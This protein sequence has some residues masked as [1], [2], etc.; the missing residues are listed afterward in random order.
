MWFP[1]D[2]KEAPVAKAAYLAEI[3]FMRIQF[4]LLLGMQNEK[5][6]LISKSLGNAYPPKL[7]VLAKLDPMIE[8]LCRS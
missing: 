3:F 8:L 6:Q 2:L 7:I 1:L 4:S 5:H